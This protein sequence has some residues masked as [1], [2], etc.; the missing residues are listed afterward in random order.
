MEFDA[1]N[2]ADSH[3]NKSV[4]H[5][6]LTVSSCWFHDFRLNIL[7]RLYDFLTKKQFYSFSPPSI[8]PFSPLYPSL[9]THSGLV[10][11]L[12]HCSF[13]SPN[14]KGSELLWACHLRTDAICYHD[15]RGS[16]RATSVTVSA[17]KPPAEDI[18]SIQKLIFWHG[19]LNIY[20]HSCCSK[21]VWNT[22]QGLGM[23]SKTIP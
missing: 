2:K 9:L 11:W 6:V 22:K 7:T 23:S 3:T 16:C 18:V 20:S 5:M 19:T 1:T 10:S 14:R 12:H 4:V 15:C 8:L 21:L 13:A 17:A